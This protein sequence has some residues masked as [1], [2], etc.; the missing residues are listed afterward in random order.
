MSSQNELKIKLTLLADSLKQGLDN[1]KKQLDALRGAGAGAGGQAAADANKNLGAIGGTA[2]KIGNDIKSAL[3]GAFAVGS[4][5]AFTHRLI[6]TVKEV[7]DLRIRL[8]GLTLSAQD[9]AASEAYLIDLAKRHHKSVQDLTGSYSAFLTLERSG[10]ITRQQSMQLL[11]GFSN[12]A[13]KTGASAMQ[14][15]QSIYGLSQALGTGV[16][17]MQDFKQIVEPMPGLANEIARTMGLTV[18]GLRELIATGTLTSEEFGRKVPAALKAYEGA[19][20]RSAGT[21]SATYSDLKNKFVELA[22]ALEKPIASSVATV[23]SGIGAAYGVLKDNGNAVINVVT[24]IAVVMVSKGA[25]ALAIYTKAGIDA[26]HVEKAHTA[27]IIE[28]EART[29]QAIQQKYNLAAAKAVDKKATTDLAIAY[30]AATE[31]TLAVERANGLAAWSYEALILAEKQQ[32]QAS[33]AA[34]AAIESQAAAE[35]FL[36]KQNLRLTESQAALAGATNASG[37]AMTRLKSA[38]AFVGGGVG[39]ALIALYG[40]YEILNKVMDV[41]GKAERKALAYDAAL[42]QINDT[43]LKLNANEVVLETAKAQQNAEEL[44]K[45]IAKLEEFNTDNILDFSK[46]ADKRRVLLDDLKLTEEKL[47]SLNQQDLELIKNF[48]ATKLDSQGKLK[49]ELDSTQAVLKQLSD[50]AGKLN[51]K[52][53]EQGKLSF[54]EQKQLD[55]D[56]LRINAF[57]AKES[58]IQKQIEVTSGAT[59]E[60]INKKK[61]AASKAAIKGIEDDLKEVIKAEEAEAARRNELAQ[62][63][64]ASRKAEIELSTAS[65]LQKELLITQATKAANDAQLLIIAHSGSEKLRITQETFAAEIEKAKASKSLSTQLDEQSLLAKQAI[66]RDM[67]KNYSAT[68]TRLVDEEVRLVNESKAI[69]TQRKGIEQSYADFKLQLHQL[70]LNDGQK[71]EEDITRLKKLASDQKKAIADGDFKTAEELNGKILELGKAIALSDKQNA[72]E[73]KKSG[74]AY[75]DNVSEVVAITDKAQASIL[76]VN[77]AAQQATKDRLS[78]TKAGAE[79]AKT[80]LQAVQIQIADIT[81]EMETKNFTLLMSADTKDVD[82]AIARISQPTQ[83]THTINVVENRGGAATTA[84]VEAH[85]TGGHVTGKGTGTSDEIPAMLSNGEYVITA[86]KVKQHGVAAFDAI[87]YG[88]VSPTNHY[89]TG[90]LVGNDKVTAKIEELKKKKFDEVSSYFNNPNTQLSWA[91]DGGHFAPQSEE[92]A[93][94]NFE[95]N[96][97]KYLRDNNLPHDFLTQYMNN[98]ALATA[99][100]KAVGFEAQAKAQIALDESQASDKP[101][102]SPSYT[103]STPAPPSITSA[104]PPAVDYPRITPS[105]FNPQISSNGSSPAQLT[106]GKTSTIKFVAP[107]GKTETG[108]F[109]GDTAGDFFTQLDTLSGV[110]KL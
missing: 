87:N 97:D 68:V 78:D 34:T 109:S 64:L 61:R 37:V 49:A 45:Q 69:A 72:E 65:T 2:N 35:A 101:S 66:Y 63:S 44:R 90:G 84:P 33:A 1:A 23:L 29:V 85:A 38:M 59:Q 9:Y 24:G 92:V 70:E 52:L 95:R 103:T 82:A 40:L 81:K 26:I 108:K 48:D 105:G 54:Y 25:S 86:D 21:L 10:I 77:D 83:S 57:E 106:A 47:K 50:E 76:K 39:V 46:N 62:S 99:V 4:L 102:E 56:N 67:E 93:K 55:E 91:F 107:S 73:A 110:T 88:N 100:K 20:A 80:Q 27:A 8:S 18:G 7:Q 17:N 31:A 79:D 28:N 43:I 104:P 3:A 32:V 16:V 94:Q 60:V 6:D 96:A 53:H 22:T 13:S 36:A 11:E 51:K 41:E 5:V 19:A 58:A 71:K 14:M 12:L 30:L 42:K 15:S 75:S 98:L 74:K 89:A